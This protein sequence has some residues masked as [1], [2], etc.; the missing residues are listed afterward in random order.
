HRAYLASSLPLGGTHPAAR[1]RRRQPVVYPITYLYATQPLGVSWYNSAH[2]EQQAKDDHEPTDSRTPSRLGSLELMS[3][4]LV[5]SSDRLGRDAQTVP[6][7]MGGRA[8]VTPAPR[9]RLHRAEVRRNLR[10]ARDRVTTTQE[11]HD[12]STNQAFARA[13]RASLESPRYD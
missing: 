2:Q 9:P 12:R 1:P 11:H 5:A 6:G 4:S 7:A 8:S 10:A 3:R 13:P